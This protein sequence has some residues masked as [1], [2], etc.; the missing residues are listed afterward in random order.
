MTG[1]TAGRP[2]RHRRS[3]WALAERRRSLR[4][5]GRSYS[6]KD[7]K[8]LW[9]A[10]AM[11]AFP[12]CRVWLV[13]RDAPSGD[14]GPA[15]IGKICH[16]VA[17]SDE[18]P[19]GDRNFPKE[20]REH[21]DNLILLCGTHHDVIDVQPNSYTSDEIR[22]W[23]FDHET[24]VESTL[25]DAIIAL[26]FSELAEVTAGLVARPPASEGLLSAPTPP[27]RKMRHNGLTPRVAH[28][29][30]QGQLRFYDIENY[31]GEA[32]AW[33]PDFG[34]RLTAG[35]RQQYDEFWDRGLRG[36]DLYIALA[37]WASGGA[38]APFPRQAAG[39]AILS[40]LFHICEVFEREPDTEQQ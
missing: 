33:S 31:L 34:G 2:V 23:K 24:W 28:Y 22:R 26:D 38:E 3:A 21:P 19:R 30:Q 16:I 8:I 6:D 37:D 18:G 5:V 32:H 15:V 4:L 25:T 29:Y 40:Y 20:R 35:F 9:G 7:L 13:L 27:A 39:V 17:H 12:A 36:D 14:D 1:A 11:C 10:H